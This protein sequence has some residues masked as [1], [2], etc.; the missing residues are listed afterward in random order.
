MQTIR[1]K[2]E[3]YQEELE[4]RFRESVRRRLI[5][6]CRWAPS[7]RGIDSSVVVAM[8]AAEGKVKT[9]TVGFEK[10][11]FRDEVPRRGRHWDRPQRDVGSPTTA[12]RPDRVGHFD[13]PFGTRPW[14]DMYVCQM[15]G[16]TS[17]GLLGTR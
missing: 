5:T 12:I 2:D 3:E 17:R 4:A 8:M 15:A 16:S 11:L 7:L 1:P 13:E 10:R 6:R 9:F 14:S